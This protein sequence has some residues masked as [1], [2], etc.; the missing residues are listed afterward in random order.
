MLNFLLRILPVIC[1]VLLSCSVPAQDSVRPALLTSIPVDGTGLP[2]Q[3]G[4]TGSLILLEAPPQTRTGND[5]WS[6]LA[7]LQ[8]DGVPVLSGDY[9]QLQLILQQRE[10]LFWQLPVWT[11]VINLLAALILLLV[12]R[13]QPGLPLFRWLL[14]LALAGNLLYLQLVTPL[15]VV[16]QLSMMG[17]YFV[18]LAVFLRT[19]QTP[20]AH[21]SQGH[22]RSSQVVLQLAVI[23]LM[24]LVVVDGV[25]LIRDVQLLNHPGLTLQLVPFGQVVGVLAALYFLTGQHAAM[26]AELESLNIS[27][28]HRVAQ[29]TAELQAR[30]RALTRD[31]LRAA[32]MNERRGIYQAIHED[33]GD[34]LLQ[35]IYS[36]A[37]TETSDL[38]RSALAEL[39]DAHNLLPDQQRPLTAVLADI[40]NET[41]NRCDQAKIVLHWQQDDP[42]PDRVL[43]A[44]QL[45]ALSRT[46]R[47]AFSN[48]FKHAQASAVAV[49][50]RCQPDGRLIYSICD[51]GRGM[52]EHAAP[53]RG[54]INMRSRVTE[55]GGTLAWA[56]GEGG[57]TIFEF[58][59]PLE[60]GV[61]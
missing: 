2:V 49:S 3:S 19:L 25:V 23:N 50:V 52:S 40:R 9:A 27:L 33:L 30:Y 26:R 56:P 39:R 14:G 8:A 5:A 12:S 60:E 20:I 24:V 55:L 28:D 16:I 45:S 22:G 21:L 59:L 29:A 51:N 53:G 57:G 54:L 48:L 43:N 15:P 44:R 41:Q 17:L 37:D 4:R 32:R 58:V 36:A 31:A 46:V 38:A 13:K 1:L 42:L 34:K 7:A 10:L 18:A 35:L 6:S 11:L 47:E 61:T